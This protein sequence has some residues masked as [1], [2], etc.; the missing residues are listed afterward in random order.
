MRGTWRSTLYEYA[1]HADWLPDV[2][3]DSVSPQEARTWLAGRYLSAFGPASRDDLQWWLGFSKGEARE[4]LK[5]LEP[6]LVEV[7]I[8]DFGNGYLMRAEDAQRLKDFGPPNV[9]CVYLLPSLDP[10]V[11]GYRDRDRFLA[12]EHRTKIFDRA[13]NAVPTAWANGR[14]VGAWGQRKDGGVI[15]GLFEPVD[16]EEAALLTDEARRLEVFLGGEYLPP[17]YRTPF[18]RALD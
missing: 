15:Y 13:G 9:P 2:D 8:Q 3:L 12:P 14:I 5:P 7:G 4:A 10:Y 17:R 16:G 11:M 6:S 18:T 1:A